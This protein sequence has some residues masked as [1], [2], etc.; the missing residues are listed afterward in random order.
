L[1]DLE[2]AGFFD[3]EHETELK[4]DYGSMWHDKVD[5]NKYFVNTSDKNKIFN[6]IITRITGQSYNYSYR[7][8]NK[9]YH[10]K[11]R[12]LHSS[13]F[14]DNNDSS[15]VYVLLFNYFDKK[16]H[17]LKT[18]I[19]EPIRLTKQNKFF[20]AYENIFQA[21]KIK[22]MFFANEIKNLEISPSCSGFSKNYNLSMLII[23]EL[24]YSKGIDFSFKVILNGKIQYTWIPIEGALSVRGDNI[25]RTD[26]HGNK[27]SEQLIFVENKRY[28]LCSLDC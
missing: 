3:E 14:L 15:I 4:M 1:D 7:N 27:L 19:N 21:D 25:F 26:E 2:D 23:D 9:K 17:W 5:T 13:I 8:M 12:S 6:E 18:N 20:G 24:L 28:R 16:I 11:G 22:E 10:M